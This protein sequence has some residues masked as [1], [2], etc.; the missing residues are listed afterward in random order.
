MRMW[1]IENPVNVGVWV[2]RR[3]VLFPQMYNILWSGQFGE[4]G[5]AS[6]GV[7]RAKYT[8]SLQL[9]TVG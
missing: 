7:I 2:V 6:N 1:V 5:A 8:N 4:V 9:S 3:I